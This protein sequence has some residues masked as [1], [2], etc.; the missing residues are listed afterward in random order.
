MD[1]GVC[2]PWWKAAGLSGLASPNCSTAL[3]QRGVA[4]RLARLRSRVTSFPAC[5]QAVDSSA[6]GRVH[7]TLWTN[8]RDSGALTLTILSHAC[9]PI[10][11]GTTACIMPA[12]CPQ[13][14]PRGPDGPSCLWKRLHLH[15]VS[16]STG[17]T[18]E[19]IAKAALAQFEGAEVRCVKHFWPMVRSRQVHL[20]IASS[21]MLDR[22]SRAGALY[23]GQCRDLR[24]PA[25][26][27]LPCI[28]RYPAM[29]VLDAVTEALEQAA[30]TA[31][32]TASPGRQHLMDEAYFSARRCDPVH[33]RARRRDRLRRTGK[34]RISCLPGC[35]ARRRRRPA[36]ISRTAAT[37]SPTSRW[38]SKARRRPRCCSRTQDHPLIVGLT[39]SV[40]SGWSR[41]AATGCSRMGESARHRLHRCREAFRQEVALCAAHVRGSRLAGDRCH[42]AFDRG[43]RGGYHPPA[44]T[45]RERWRGRRRSGGRVRRGQADMS[46]SAPFGTG[47]RAR[48]HRAGLGQRLAPGHATQQPDSCASRPFRPGS[49]SAALAGRDGGQRAGRRSPRRSRRRRRSAV[50]SPRGRS[51]L[52]AGQRFARRGRRSRRFDKPIEL[53]RRRP[54]ISALFSGQDDDCCTAPPRWRCGG[55]GSTGWRAIPAARGCR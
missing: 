10:A 50:S 40:P 16:D 24:A 6:A 25:R 42:A 4:D 47:L 8:R 2:W 46:P 49:T 52:G 20:A 32:P 51:Q 30:G 35:R 5:P 34:R 3:T 39:N 23:A 13:A 28:L 36:S 44:E 26:G 22:E 38:W 21:P 53:A 7:A 19:M 45:E 1:D 18:L 12:S 27:A 14:D 48:E 33:H 11:P 54:S 31:R 41:F 55:A 17:E 15:L 43:D 9:R 37:R 29:P